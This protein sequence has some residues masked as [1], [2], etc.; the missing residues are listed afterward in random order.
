MMMQDRFS[1]TE[2]FKQSVS[3]ALY[4][5]IRDLALYP[6]NIAKRRGTSAV[7]FLIGRESGCGAHADGPCLILTKRS[8]DVKQPGDLC[9][10]GGHTLPL[11]DK[12]IGRLLALPGSPI[13]RWPH[14]YRWRRRHRHEAAPMVQLLAT[15]IR[16]SLEE[17]RLN[18]LGL[19]VLGLLPPQRLVMFQREIFPL[20]CHVDR[21]QTFVPNWEVARIHY[22]PLS[23]MLQKDNYACY[24]LRF[25][26]L[27][28]DHAKSMVKDFP[29]FVHREDGRTEYLWG[30]TFRI[31]MLFLKLAFNFEPPE[32]DHLPIVNGHLERNYVRGKA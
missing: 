5:H 15:G 26:G 8:P 18:P 31:A 32:W 2:H 20:V 29:C 3:D 14:W 9:C 12:L 1:D 10:P 7:L 21:R 23:A 17:M 6:Q 16:E 4:R 19:T 25:D 27:Q 13:R 22:L 11:I 28:A 30:A 24:R